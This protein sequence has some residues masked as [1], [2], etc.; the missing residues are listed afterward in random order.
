MR[1]YNFTFLFLL[2]Y[3][4]VITNC[5]IFKKCF[6]NNKSSLDENFQCVKFEVK[7]KVNQYFIHYNGWNKK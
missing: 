5:S 4:P 6:R 7:D 3:L 1:H 2:K